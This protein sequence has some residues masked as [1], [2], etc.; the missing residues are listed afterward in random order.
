MTPKYL[1]FEEL[2]FYLRSRGRFNNLC[3]DI[4]SQFQVSRQNKKFPF[5]Q[6]VEFVQE[7]PYCLFQLFMLNKTPWIDWGLFKDIEDLYIKY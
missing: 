7:D 3:F 5:Y 6:G 1:G 2:T 4:K